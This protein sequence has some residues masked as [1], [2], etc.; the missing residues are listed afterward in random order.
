MKHPAEIVPILIAATALAVAFRLRRRGRRGLLGA[1]I[2][3]RPR[4]AAA[5][6][7]RRPFSGV[8]GL[9]ASREIR[10]RIR[11][12]VFRVATAFILAGVAAAVVIPAVNHG[13][14]HPQQ[15]G[16]VGAAPSSL[17]QAIASAGTAVRTA[18][19]VVDEPN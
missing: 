18:V 3:R 12:R 10:Q 6:T 1:L 9:V 2:E 19:H 17:P 5:E 11:G 8:V 13:N 14:A 16:V 4:R 7:G 15:V